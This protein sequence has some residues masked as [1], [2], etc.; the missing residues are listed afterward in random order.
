MA[1][2]S[3]NTMFEIPTERPIQNSLSINLHPAIRTSVSSYFCDAVTD[4]L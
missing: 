3:V 1:F 2:R 4:T